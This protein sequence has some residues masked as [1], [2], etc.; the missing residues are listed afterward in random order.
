MSG[1]VV[2]HDIVAPRYE[3]RGQ[4][5]RCGA[6][7]L[8]EKCDRLAFADGKAAC[9]WYPDNRPEKCHVFPGNPPIVFK[10]CGY[11]FWDTWEKREIHPGDKV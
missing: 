9:R 1:I 7:C 10:S 11:W 5:I 8:N 6:C 3:R 2:P 4:C